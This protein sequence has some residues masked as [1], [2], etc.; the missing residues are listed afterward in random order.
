M[1]SEPVFEYDTSVTEWWTKISAKRH[2]LD[3]ATRGKVS[4]ASFQ[5]LTPVEEHDVVSQVLYMLQD[6]ECDYFVL[7]DT[8]NPV[9]ER[10]EEDC[11]VSKSYEAFW[12]WIVSPKVS[13]GAPSLKNLTSTSLGSQ[14]AHFLEMAKQKSRLKRTAKE[15]R[16]GFGFTSRLF[17]LGLSK[18]LQTIES[19]FYEIQKEHEKKKKTLLE[20]HERTMDLWEVLK[21]LSALS[22]EAVSPLPNLDYSALV[23]DLYPDR[24]KKSLA[25]RTAT[26][27]RVLEAHLASA[28]HEIKYKLCLALFVHCLAPYLETIDLWMLHA[29]LAPHDRDE[30]CVIQLAHEPVDSPIFWDSNYASIS[31]EAPLF[32]RPSLHHILETGKASLLLQ[33]IQHSLLHLKHPEPLPNDV[34][35]P[36]YAS[37]KSKLLLHFHNS[38]HIFVGDDID[39]LPTSIDLLLSSSDSQSHESLSEGK[40]MIISENDDDHPISPSN[41]SGTT[42]PIVDAKLDIIISKSLSEKCDFNAKV[43]A[44]TAFFNSEMYGADSEWPSSF[45]DCDTQE[46]AIGSAT[47]TETN[48]QDAQL[49]LDKV[50]NFGIPISSVFQECIAAPIE[51]RYKV[52]N[53][54]LMQVLKS[55]CKVLKHIEA[56]QKM[57]FLQAPMLDL[58]SLSVLPSLW[59]YMPVGEVTL[60]HWLKQAI[61]G[62]GASNEQKECFYCVSLHVIKKSKVNSSMQKLES[63]DE[64]QVKSL[65]SLEDMSK[66]FVEY[67]APWPTSLFLNGTTIQLYNSISSSMTALMASQYALEQLTT[68]NKKHEANGLGTAASSLHKMQLFKKELH[69]FV[70]SVREYMISRIMQV[71]W[72]ELE[73]EL[74][75]AADLDD[76]LARHTAYLTQIRERCLLSEKFAAV[77]KAMDRIV[78]IAIDFSRQFQVFHASLNP[79]THATSSQTTHASPFASNSVFLAGMGVDGMS[80]D[81]LLALLLRQRSEFIK[82]HKFLLSILSKMAPSSIHI[83]DLL[84]R[85]N[86]SGFYDQ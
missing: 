13:E 84:L 70:R 49:P 67:S 11:L 7:E 69:L 27:F 4:V 17:A 28:E 48:E 73:E 1:S 63:E 61:E 19:R 54:R 5:A 81:R 25:A 47:V 60:N 78:D 33:Y 42:S 44:E 83:A 66:I 65:R 18:L 16:K 71:P 32:L 12:T 72:S 21:F 82:L 68:I 37:T 46:C 80:Q 8:V 55:D 53:E 22:E 36:L 34:L 79:S 20:L 26:L 52:V 38:H 85:L 9:K 31:H 51:A 58:Y 77:R 23:D 74:Q 6:L 45:E 29:H 59:S 86:F 40:Q 24:P 43:K 14:L 35:Q 56:A 15:A 57:F 76:M 30:F 75:N 64:M 41:A 39:S 3:E 10:E 2:P 62:I 50:G